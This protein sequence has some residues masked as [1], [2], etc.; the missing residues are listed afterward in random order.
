MLVP[1]WFGHF[2][3]DFSSKL[4]Q[5]FLRVYPPG[6]DTTSNFVHRLMASYISYTIIFKNCF[7]FRHC[8]IKYETAELN[9]LWIVWSEMVLWCQNGGISEELYKCLMGEFWMKVWSLV[10]EL[11]KWILFVVEQ[12]VGCEN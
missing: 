5:I 1:I 9:F 10:S 12:L 8:F 6:R 2:L 11:G 3:L 7:D 4:L